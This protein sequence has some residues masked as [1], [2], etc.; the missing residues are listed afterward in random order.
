MR[1][2]NVAVVGGGAAGAM[3]AIRASQLKKDVVLIERNRSIGKKLLLSGGGRC[4]ITNIASIEE[5]IEAFGKQ[6]SFSRT[7]FSK[8]FNSDLISFFE[9]EGLSMKTESRG[10]VFPVTDSAASV[11][12]ILTKCLIKN[13]IEIFY[14]SRLR[15]IKEKQ[16]FFQLNLENK[17]KI[18]A[19]KV[20]LA[21]G[22]LSYKGCG[23]SGD[24]FCI[25]K[26]LGHVI[27]PLIPALVPLRT[28]EKWVKQ[29]QGI[30]LADVR[31]VFKYS[32]KK[33]LS[34]IGDVI[35]THFGISGPLVLDSSNKIVGII[36][37]H[38]KVLL[39]IDLKPKL[40]LE[41]LRG[42]LL[43][44]SK[45]KINVQ[46]N[47]FMKSLLPRRLVS[48]FLELSAIEPQKKI[49]KIRPKELNTIVNLLKY[50][51]LTV[52]GFLSIEEAMITGGG[53][54]LK[55]IDPRTMQSRIVEG[56]YFAGEIIDGCGISG[57]YNMQQ[58]FSTG[59]LAGQEASSASRS[60][61][62]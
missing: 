62:K 17:D 49:R 16:D 57:G 59:Y 52:T 10:R 42:L 1:I 7:A 36:A 32:N 48:V 47:N 51:P 54:S 15:N 18:Y 50:F 21:T 5:F 11:V 25:A 61:P 39:F 22:G 53:I 26:E 58:A 24:G 44:E 30:S 14:K 29:L 6:G 9:S 38:K 43:K 23:S 34:A 8:F 33:I 35:F 60:F 46:L 40:S 2:Y 19:N 41:Q 20:I 27:E 3:A 56:I 31:L 12:K 4:N 13:G 28:K 37:K 45:S 55:E